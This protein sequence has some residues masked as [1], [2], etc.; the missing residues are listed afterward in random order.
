MNGRVRELRNDISK[1]KCLLRNKFQSFPI[2]RAKSGG[3]SQKNTNLNRP[4]ILA[5]MNEVENYFWWKHFSARKLIK[6]E[7][8]NESSFYSFLFRVFWC[9]TQHKR[10]GNVVNK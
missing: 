6:N 8:F 2:L 10:V 4:L 7:L 9:L 3:L 1:P 5:M